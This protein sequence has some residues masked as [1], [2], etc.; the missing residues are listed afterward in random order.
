MALCLERKDGESILIGDE[1]VVTVREAHRGW[2]KLAIVAPREIRVDRREV[3][4]R[5]EQERAT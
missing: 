5:I 2:V 4:L 1:I 3:R